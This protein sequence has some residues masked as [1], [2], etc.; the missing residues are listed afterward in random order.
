MI[1]ASRKAYSLR[2]LL[3]SL[4]HAKSIFKV[5]AIGETFWHASLRHQWRKR[6]P[7][8]LAYDAT[9]EPMATAQPLPAM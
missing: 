4:I 9:E 3:H 1:D 5:L 2:R 8:L 6:L 7:E